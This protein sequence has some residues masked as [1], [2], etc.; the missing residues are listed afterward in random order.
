MAGKREEVGEGD[1][2]A[3]YNVTRATHPERLCNLFD[4]STTWLQQLS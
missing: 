2:Q 3:V 4:E 1:R